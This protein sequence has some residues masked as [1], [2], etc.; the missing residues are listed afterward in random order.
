M[1][2]AEHNGCAGERQQ[3]CWEW[4]IVN[5]PAAHGIQ[6]DIAAGAQNLLL[7]PL[8]EWGGDGVHGINGVLVW[9]WFTVGPVGPW[10]HPVIISCPWIY[11]WKEWNLVLGLWE[12]E[13]LW[14]DR[15]YC[16]TASLSPGKTG[17]QRQYCDLVRQEYF[18]ETLKD[19]VIS[20]C[21]SV[22]GWVLLHDN[23]LPQSK[24]RTSP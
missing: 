4:L 3:R 21:K 16:E 2:V 18:S 8:L 9:V 17:S 10:G 1:T 13:L 24:P 11:T 14:E 7:L 19:L 12:R 15:L 5:L 22:W 23:E 6:V 20:P